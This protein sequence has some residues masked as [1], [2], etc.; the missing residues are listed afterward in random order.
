MPRIQSEDYDQFVRE[1]GGNNREKLLEKKRERKEA[2]KKRDLERE[3]ARKA[4][5]GKR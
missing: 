3:A 5:V 2:D 4:K 1:M